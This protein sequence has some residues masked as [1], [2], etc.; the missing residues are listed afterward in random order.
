MYWNKQL[1]ISLRRY[2]LNITIV[3]LTFVVMVMAISSMNRPLPEA[4]S[5]ILWIIVAFF[6]FVVSLLVMGGI[7]KVFRSMK[8]N[9]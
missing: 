9:K 1:E 3:L 4:L 6:T 8:G 5:P 7:A 2:K